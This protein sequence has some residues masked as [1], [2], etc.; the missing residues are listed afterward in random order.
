MKKRFFV[1][2]VAAVMLFMHVSCGD[3]DYSGAYN[4]P[5]FPLHL[6]NT[7]T[8][9]GVIFWYEQWYV[10][11]YLVQGPEWASVYLAKSPGPGTP[12]DKT[13]NVLKSTSNWY[14][15]TEIDSVV[16]ASGTVYFDCEKW[17]LIANEYGNWS[18]AWSNG[19]WR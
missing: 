19:P 12:V 9:S 4:I 16:I 6:R 14:V 2:F 10:L 17:L 13:I 5:N 11:G 15:Q 1:V 3:L 18:C 8:T 7:S